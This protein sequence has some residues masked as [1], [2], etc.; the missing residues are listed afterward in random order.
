MRKLLHNA[1]IRVKAF[2]ASAVLLLFLMALGSLAYMTAGRAVSDLSTLSQAILPKQQAIA[3]LNEDTNAVQ[4]KV[5]RFAT[6]S[7][8]GVNAR[9][10]V[11]LSSEIYNDLHRI[12]E[13]MVTLDG[14]D[15]M[16]KGEHSTIGDLKAKWEKYVAAVNDTLDVG[17][18]DAPMATMMLGGTDDDFQKIAV[19]LRLLAALVD[20]QT[21]E[22]TRQVV[23]RAEANRQILAIGAIA[24]V[25][26]SIAVT[27]IVGRSIVTPVHAITKAMRDPSLDSSEIESAYR[28]RTDEVGQMV[29]AIAGFRRNLNRQ[30]LQLDTALNSLTQGLCMFDAEQRVAVCNDRFAQMYGLSP[31]RQKPGTAHHDIIEQRIAAG[32]YAGTSPDA[33][34]AQQIQPVTRAT[35]SIQELSDGRSIVVTSRPMAGGGWATTH[36]DISERRRAE[37]RIAYMAHHDALTDLPNRLRFHERVATALKRVARGETVA[38]LCLDLDRFKSVNDTLGHPVGDVLL[39]QVTDRLRKSIRESDT[40]ARLGGD[41]FAIVQTEAQ[42]PHAATALARRLIEVL[43]EPYMIDGFEV[44]IGASVGL[45]IAPADGTDADQLL[46]NGDLALY[47]AK[48]DGRGTYRFFEPDMDARMQARSALEFDLRRAL[49][50]NEFEVFYQP[51]INVKQNE[52]ASFEALLRWHHPQR[53]MVSPEDFIPLAEEIGLIVPIGEWVMQRACRDAATWPAHISV[54][55]NLSPV[56]FRG[57][58]ILEMVM[59]ALAIAKLPANRLVLE[60]TEGV[61]LVETEPTLALLY[62]LRSLGVRVAL[63]DFGTGYSSLSYLRSFPFD[64]VKVDSSFVRDITADDSS[65][66]IIRAVI[67]L[68]ASLGMATTAEGVETP[69]Q[70]DRIRSEGCTEVQGFLFSAPRPVADVTGMLRLDWASEAAA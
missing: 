57:K 2:A 23:S 50:Q 1:P 52:V 67:G 5:S 27:L 62:Q 56:Q 32:L 59:T 6:W 11:D 63:D 13:Q 53:G 25:L 30:N 47:R 48:S 12:A 35:T 49:A 9:L 69:E 39:R 28:D 41:E 33:Y 40:V 70:L 38:I 60:I 3:N 64:K 34:R 45:A 44:V 68:S 14:R 19:D 46:K 58:K 18:T 51:V 21:R 55:V 54:S 42:Q 10:L 36:E 22:V 4:V 31:D 37:R 17:L 15:D 61:L 26:L 24:G 66:A 65:V 16:S 43:S 29:T 8:N 20:A 7:S